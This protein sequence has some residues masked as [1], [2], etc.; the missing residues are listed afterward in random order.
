MIDIAIVVI[1]TLVAM[2][3]SSYLFGLSQVDFL[4]K[5][6]VEYRCNP[7]YMPMAGLVGQDISRN[8]T[9]CT[10]KGFHDYAGFIMDPLLSQ[11]SVVNETL[12]EIGG[13]MN[14]MRQ[15]SADVRGGFLGII[16]SVFGK[17]Q[18]LMSQF[19]YIIIRM[20]TL[21]GRVVGVMM[22]FL[23]IFTGGM[24]TGNSINNGPIMKTMSFLCFAKDTPI[25]L[26]NDRVALIQN[27]SIGTVLEA[28][29]AV[30]SLY[31]IDGKGV[32]MYD[33]M[34]ITVSGNHKVL[35]EKTAIFVKDHPD[36]LRV[37]PVDM[38]YCLNTT[39]GFIP[40][41]TELFLDFRE[42][43]DTFGLA[44][45]RVHIERVY[46]E[47]LDVKN[48]V[49]SHVT[50]VLGTTLVPLKNRNAPIHTV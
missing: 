9:E 49:P 32:P 17:I 26:P 21:M 22:G 38:L 19:Q 36:A 4:K 45:K 41:F 39:S 20:R 33:L 31:K 8:F 50:G 47:T 30:V 5:N 2:I 15:M 35:Y 11:F 40:T 14:S 42:T 16:G 18:N 23:Y 37:P 43:S 46:N 6:W 1:A 29:E 7:I 3:A 48:A 25:C 44:M 28:G 27:I 24:E 13:A 10:M 34:G 12:G